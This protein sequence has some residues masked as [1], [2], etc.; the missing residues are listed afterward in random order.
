MRA[1]FLILALLASNTWAATWYIDNRLTTGSNN[2]TSAANAWRTLYDSAYGT[3]S[4]TVAPGDTIE[5]VAGSGPYYEATNTTAGKR[6]SSTTISFDAATKTIATSGAENLALYLAN[7]YIR[8][9]GATNPENNGQFRVASSSTSA[10]VLQSTYNLVTEASGATVRIADI[11]PAASAVYVFDQGRHGTVTGGRITWNLNGCE[12]SAGWPL[13]TQEFKWLRSRGGTNEWYVVRQDGSNPGLVRPESAV[14]DGFYMVASATDND[15]KRGTV[16]SLS[17]AR[18][19][20]YGDG[21]SLG[22]STVYVRTN[23]GAP[24]NVIVNQVPFVVY[25]GW[26]N[27][28]F[29]NGVWSFGN[30]SAN[31]SVD[32]SVV[33]GRANDMRLERMTGRWADGQAWELRSPNTQTPTFSSSSGLLATYATDIPNLSEVRFTNSGGAL[34]TGLVAGTSYYTIRVSTTTSRLATSVDNAINGT[35]IAFTNAG[36]GTQTMLPMLG[37]TIQSSACIWPG[38]RCAANTGNGRLRFINSIDWGAHVGIL[39]ST[40][41]T[42]GAIDVQNSIFANEEAGAIDMK[43]AGCTLTE[44]YNHFYPRMTDPDG[45]LAN[46]SQARWATTAATDNPASTATTES[47]QGALVDP[48]FV[49]TP[50]E[51]V[52]SILSFKLRGS[53]VARRTG[54]D[55]NLGKMQDCDN[56]AFLHPPSRGACEAASG[57]AAAARTA[58]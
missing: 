25:A 44:S 33:L 4:G 34:P 22:F 26:N 9:S 28:T 24:G 55:L 47:D 41:C 48:E 15:R 18:Q 11:T 30:G 45:N 42:T 21:D 43:V 36:T 20:A 49:V 3:N 58:R 7:A 35:A 2:G 23:G 1:L 31:G 46:G 52:S 13:N 10:I 29:R 53:S 16:G 54:L 56:R 37:L 8:V 6:I 19:Y 40:L 32:G 39:G 14:V 27:H 51:T 57:D 12:F 38:H 50:S 5:C 17:Y